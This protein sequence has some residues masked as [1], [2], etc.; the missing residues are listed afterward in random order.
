MGDGVGGR[1]GGRKRGMIFAVGEVGGSRQKSDG[2]RA[3]DT[4]EAVTYGVRFGADSGRVD[5]E[6][7]GG[8]ARK[9]RERSSSSCP[10]CDTAVVSC[11]PRPSEKIVALNS[12]VAAP[13]VRHETRMT[14]G[15]ARIEELVRANRRLS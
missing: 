8:R 7:N 4:Y 14:Y 6:V 3:D 10:E 15:I 12:H 11:A 2:A 13:A 9:H 1:E 5:E